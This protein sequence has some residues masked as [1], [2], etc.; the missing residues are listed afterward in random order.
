MCKYGVLLIEN[1]LT[2][3]REI[4]RNLCKDFSIYPEEIEFVKLAD[5]A[6]ISLTKRYD[7]ASIQP[8]KRREKATKE[9]VDYINS[10]EIEVIILDHVLVGHYSSENGIHLYRKLKELKVEQPIIFLSRTPQNDSKVQEDLRKQEI[11]DPIWVEKGYAG[12]GIGDDWYFK[13]N[14]GN[15]ILKCIGQSIDQRLDKIINSGAFS[16]MIDQINLLRGKPFNKG[17]KNELNIFL[18]NYPNL[19]VADHNGLKILINKW[20]YEWTQSE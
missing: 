9:L 8:G 14:V 15:E 18:S 7:F 10:K 17:E 3:Y 12:Q 2:Q 4:R 20:N 1:Q 16:D 13:K 6:R 11:N 19:A 5:W